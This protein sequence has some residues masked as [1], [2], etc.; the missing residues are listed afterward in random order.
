MLV[1]ARQRSWLSAA[2]SLLAACAAPSS[3][4][5]DLRWYLQNRASQFSVRGPERE[6]IYEA[7]L[8]EIRA[9]LAGSTT[10]EQILLNPAIYDGVVPAVNLG[11][12]DTTWTTRVLA[13][14]LVEGIGA[15]KAST[16]HRA[17]L[18]SLGIPWRLPGDTVAL[19]AGYDVAPRLST[20][21]CQVYCGAET[22]WTLYLVKG[23]A[24]WTIARAGKAAF[25]H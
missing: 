18:V 5:A 4:A 7:A 14:G 2:L 12:H 22:W 21:E 8:R 6:A 19:D 23:S 25:L 24:G 16:A 11:A 9:K 20:S 17:F 13:R 15:S 10:I 3:E 1:V